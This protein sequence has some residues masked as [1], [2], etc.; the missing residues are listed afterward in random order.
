MSNSKTWNLVLSIWH[1][2]EGE[3][4]AQRLCYA[5]KE[6]RTIALNGFL[7]QSESACAAYTF[8]PD[9]YGSG[10]VLERDDL[11]SIHY[12]TEDPPKP[13]E[14]VALNGK[15][16]VAIKSSDGCDV[17]YPAAWFGIESKPAAAAM[18]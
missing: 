3:C 14:T 8:E 2:D 9:L 17:L 12:R 10:L 16:Y 4:G 11:S 1:L 13:P 15:D 18:N 6:D 7:R 5:S